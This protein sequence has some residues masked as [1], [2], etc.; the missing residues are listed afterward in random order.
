VAR[1]PIIGIAAALPRRPQWPGHPST[2]APPP[3]VLP[4]RILLKSQKDPIDLWLVSTS[5]EADQPAAAAGTLEQGAPAV[6]MWR[7]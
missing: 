7:R 2:V 6:P 4:A 5:H 1:S 3:P